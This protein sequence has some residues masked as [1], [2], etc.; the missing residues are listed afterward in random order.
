MRLLKAVERLV[1]DA[2]CG[3]LS[4]ETMSMSVREM[5]LSRPPTSAS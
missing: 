2:L 3:T 5:K 1:I 4:R